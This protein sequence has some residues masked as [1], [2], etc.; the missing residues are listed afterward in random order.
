MDMLGAKS[1][2]S[3]AD[4]KQA[5]DLI[6][7]L[8]KSDRLLPYGQVSSARLKANAILILPKDGALNRIACGEL[9]IE[10]RFFTQIALKLSDSRSFSGS[11]GVFNRHGSMR[12]LRDSNPRQ[13]LWVQAK[14]NNERNSVS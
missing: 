9:N 11:Y 13:G 4:I 7:G 1:Q 5:N 10:G 6:P 3:P 14:E 12:K 8:N 2:E